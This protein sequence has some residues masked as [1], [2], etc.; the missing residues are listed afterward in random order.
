MSDPKSFTTCFAVVGLTFPNLFA[1][2]ATTAS[3]NFFK[4]F[5]VTE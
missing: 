4:S 2:G 1:D 3:F 5:V